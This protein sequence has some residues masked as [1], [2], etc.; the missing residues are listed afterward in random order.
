M[1]RNVDDWNGEHFTFRLDGVPRDAV[2]TFVP[3]H[4]GPAGPAV[5]IPDADFLL[6]ADFKRS[7]SDLILS[8]DHKTT[9]VRDYFATD[10][11]ATLF[12][13][14]GMTL[15]PEVVEALAGPLAPGQYAQA[16]GAQQ[17]AQAVGRVAKVDGN[18]TV[19]RN[20]VA[21]TVNV[22]DAIL[23]GDVLQTAS[24]Q[25]GVTFNDGST[26]N[27]TENARLV[28]NEFIYDPNSKANSQILNLVQGSLTFISGEVAHSGD[29]KIGTPVATMGIRGTVGIITGAETD[30][31]RF[32]IV[33]SDQG[34]VLIDSN[35]NIIAQVVQNGP[36]IVLRPTGPLQVIAEQVQKSPAEVAA[37]LAA[38]QHIVSVQAVGQQIIQQFFNP[39]PDPNNPQSTGSDST[40]IQIDIPKS[41]IF[42]ENANG[43]SNGGDTGGNTATVTVVTTNNNTPNTPP[44]VVEQTT[45]EIPANLPPIIFTPFASA[46][47]S[48][49]GLANGI[50][51][52]VGNTDTTDSAVV[53]GTI[54]AGDGNGDPLTFTLGAPTTALTSNGVAVTW[55]GVGTST[56]TG[57]AGADTVITI[58]I[59][60]QTG[61]YT[62]TLSGP[63]DH[64][65][66]T[67]ED[68]KVFNVPVNVSDGQSTKTSV[69]AV[70]IED[71]QPVAVTYQENVSAGV[72]VAA[73][74]VN[75]VVI[76]DISGSMAGSNITLAKQALDN[77]LTTGNV[78]INQVMAVS[79]EDGATVHQDQGSV[80]TDAA[81]ANTFIQGLTTGGG[82]N[83]QAA[84]TAV[85]NNWGGGPSGA[86][87]TLIYFISDG[88]PNSPL[89]SGETTNWENFLAANGVDVSY[90]IGISTSVNDPELA[91]IA[92]KAPDDPDFSPIV[93][94]DA[95]GLDATLQDTVSGTH[96]ILT[97]D[98]SA[99][100]GAD[101]GHILS[102]EVDGVIYSWN[103]FDTITKSGLATGT[104]AASM[105][106]LDTVLGGHFEFY[107][108]AGN[109][110]QA[111]DWSYLAPDQIAQ[112]T[113]E[114]FHYVLT[115]NDGD[116][117]GADITV[118]V[119][120]AN[121]A[122]AI[123]AHGLVAT[124]V[125]DSDDSTV[126][127]L[128]ISDVDDTGDPVAL[129]VTVDSG[130][131]TFGSL[132]QNVTL[133]GNGSS[134]PT[135]EGTVDALNDLFNAGFTYSPNGASG[136][137]MITMTVTDAQGASDTLHFV[138][139]IDNPLNTPI[140]LNGTTGKDFIF[141]TG[142]D[143][144][145]TGNGSSDTFVFFAVDV[146]GNDHVADFSL[147]DDFLQFDQALFL[148]QTVADLLSGASVHEDNG[149]TVFT[150]DGGAATIT[151]NNVSLADLVQHQDHV[152]IV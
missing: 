27:L 76:L 54:D 7:G 137:D 123:D 20:G 67:E 80:W 21:I 140:V 112:L 14:N 1:L 30:N 119:S 64:P 90:A 150:V 127:G 129:A 142:N 144:T 75:I 120:A 3:V 13:G 117:A 63:V 84:L 26:V 51:D 48:E 25:L 41:A 121:L 2:S 103:G 102:V 95:S 66:V 79:F 136:N 114:V 56:L 145:L 19:V 98:A 73:T 113:D 94:S 128:V 59:N 108:A 134:T 138:F 47:L 132:V 16:G 118:S 68:V 33:Q 58:A 45:V 82:T 57:K 55:Q 74:T 24:G 62:V 100:F 72:A 65:N 77:L 87:E 10:E 124:D 139:N 12:A 85:M 53:Q 52:S 97:D 40:Q 110:H 151:V 61:A 104:L 9:I 89:T 71:D 130:T 8:G 34:A 29:M 86:D 116:T 46:Q 60:A 106:A 49:E 148:G 4:D 141:A 122:P 37:E 70:T 43:G 18:V 133:G 93:L 23:K 146:G 147:L 22:G 81:S 143:D 101:G 105:I 126:T 99:G 96:N 135:A 38:L 17:A 31:V 131:L 50:A 28:V 109:G 32:S 35:N 69:L 36:M 91:P 44:Q 39:N 92:W 125:P 149:S 107:F 15:S 42:G 88:A 83:Y 78:Q 111:G 11:R 6:H 115:D 5:T 152:L